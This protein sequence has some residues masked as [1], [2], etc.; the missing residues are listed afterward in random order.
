VILE[1]DPEALAIDWNSASPAGCTASELEREPA[2]AASYG[3]LP[4]A[5]SKP[6]SYEAWS[7]ALADTL[8]RGMQLELFKS[9]SL[10][11]V[12]QPNEDERAF[13]IRL[14]HAA[15][16]ERDRGAEKLRSKYAP[17]VQ[18]LQDQLRRA[19]DRIAREQAVWAY[20]FSVGARQQ[21]H[22]LNGRAM[23]LGAQDREKK[24]TAHYADLVRFAAAGIRALVRNETD[25]AALSKGPEGRVTK[26][27][28]NRKPSPSRTH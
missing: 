15:R 2:D 21:A 12:S 4:A 5:A 10:G 26:P 22:A 8:F 24:S 14:Q 1:L 17:R 18:S 19:Q 7:K 9:P 3:D 11:L 25:L 16:E 6:K 13:R 27:P 23:R 20:L 28:S